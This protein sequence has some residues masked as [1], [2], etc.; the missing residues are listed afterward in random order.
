MIIPTYARYDNVLRIV[1]GFASLCKV[2]YVICVSV[3]EN[4]ECEKN[5]RQLK[6]KLSGIDIY[7]IFHPR[8]IGAFENAKYC[9]DTARLV[10]YSCDYLLFVEDDVTVNKLF[11]EVLSE[12]IRRFQMF[13]EFA[14]VTFTGVSGRGNCSF[15]PSFLMPSSIVLFNGEQLEVC[16]ND[17]IGPKEYSEFSKNFIFNLKLLVL[18]PFHFVLWYSKVREGDVSYGDIS[19]F[20]RNVFHNRRGCIPS[21]SLVGSSGF[22]A[23]A[24]N[25]ISRYEEFYKKRIIPDELAF[26]C[27]IS[28]PRLFHIFL[29]TLR[30]WL[31]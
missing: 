6:D 21:Y 10:E 27:T 15:Y 14:Y 5:Y 28:K 25:M 4:P 17:P 9:L 30:R 16:D 20:F 26:S 1:T 8:N 18:S 7:F 31:Y 2:P 24:N 22:D 11:F 19:I 23:V 13:S 3:D 12:V 29:F